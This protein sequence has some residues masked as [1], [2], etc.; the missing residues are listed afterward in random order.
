MLCFDVMSLCYVL[1]LC[2]DALFQ[3]SNTPLSSRALR[4]NLEATVDWS[5]RRRL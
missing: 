2:F 1:M 4:S 5:L 3:V